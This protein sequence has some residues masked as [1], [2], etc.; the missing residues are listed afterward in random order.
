MPKVDATRTCWQCD[1]PLPTAMR[2][3]GRFCNST[4]RT[5]AYRSGR[6]DIAESALRWLR[7]GPGQL[8]G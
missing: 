6:V 2:A 1:K 4:C 3:D 7:G 8:A 5:R